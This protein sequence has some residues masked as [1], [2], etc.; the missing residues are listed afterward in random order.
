LVTVAI[1]TLITHQKV[2]TVRGVRS[3]SSPV[4]T[5]NI[6]WVVIHWYIHKNIHIHNV[7]WWT[8]QT[9]TTLHH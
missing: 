3:M 2:K 8:T 6:H 1:I 4:A 5:D 7:R 9:T